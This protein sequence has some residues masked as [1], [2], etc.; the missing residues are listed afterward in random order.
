MQAQYGITVHG[1]VILVLGDEKEV[2]LSRNGPKS[3]HRLAQRIV[4]VT[5]K[6]L[7]EE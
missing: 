4:E 2:E 3:Q 6:E 5:H 7:T 1:K